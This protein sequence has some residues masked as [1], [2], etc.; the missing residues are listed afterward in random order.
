MAARVR[1]SGVAE[2]ESERTRRNCGLGPTKSKRLLRAVALILLVIAG[3]AAIR[4]A[5]SAHS[6]RHRSEIEAVS[7]LA[8]DY[9]LDPT[10]ARWRA[11]PFAADFD[12]TSSSSVV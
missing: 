3:Y 10:D 2:L 4:V 7:T 12:V 1:R 8:V 11:L 6:E 9:V 5:I